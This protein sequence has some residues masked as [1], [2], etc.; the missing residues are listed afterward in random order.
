MALGPLEIKK[1]RADR[2]DLSIMEFLSRGRTVDQAAE[3]FDVTPRWI[4]LLLRDA[5]KDAKTT[6]GRN[7]D[8]RMQP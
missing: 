7:Q 5:R 4:Q 2:R 3:R 1:R 8:V 6:L